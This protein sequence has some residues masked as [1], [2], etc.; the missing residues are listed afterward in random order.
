MPVPING[1][2]DGHKNNMWHNKNTLFS[3][4]RIYLTQLHECFATNYE[5]WNRIPQ[6]YICLFSIAL[7]YIH[8][9]KELSFYLLVYLFRYLFTKMFKKFK[10]KNK[11]KL[12]FCNWQPI[13]AEL[14]S[15][16]IYTLTFLQTSHFSEEGVWLTK[17]QFR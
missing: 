8:V 1:F 10:I 3:F 12:S 17:Q 11:M 13:W 4:Y 7:V 16:P 5:M 14:Y 9:H 15:Q 6:P 2:L